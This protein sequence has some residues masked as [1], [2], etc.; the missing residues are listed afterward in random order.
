MV[1]E[2]IV[3]VDG[4][5]VSHTKYVR[6]DAEPAQPRP[7]SLAEQIY[8]IVQ[9]NPG[10]RAGALASAIS[11]KKDSVSATL[12]ELK[13]RGLVINGAGECN[14]WQWTV[15]DATPPWKGWVPPEGIEPSSLG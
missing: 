6:S 4:V 10:I 7:R 1:I 11:A 2:T 3:L 14:S 9:E 13:S 5:M 12:S 8:A 15:T